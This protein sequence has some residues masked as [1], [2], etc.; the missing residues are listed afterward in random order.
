MKGLV[1][2]PSHLHACRSPEAAKLPNGVPEVDVQ[3][4]AFRCHHALEE[5]VE[6][7]L[8]A[9]LGGALKEG[10]QDVGVGVEEGGWTGA[11]GQERR[12]VLSDVGHRREEAGSCG[13]QVDRDEIKARGRQHAGLEH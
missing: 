11:F 13:L 4:A 8:G 10:Q 1:R 7:L 9:V 3:E 12:L 2:K 6:I 5:A